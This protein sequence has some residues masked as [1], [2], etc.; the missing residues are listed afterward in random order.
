MQLK[1]LIRALDAVLRRYH[2]IDEFIS[3]DDCLLR[4]A[5]V[6]SDHDLTLSDGT[7]IARGQLVGELHFWNEHIP[8]MGRGGPDLAWAVTFQHRMVKSLQDLASHIERNSRLRD[9][10][11]FRGCFGSHHRL[12]QIGA[13]AERWGFELVTPDSEWGYWKRFGDFWERIYA[14]VLIWTFNRPSLRGKRWRRLKRGQ[15]W[16]SRNLLLKR[17]GSDGVSPDY[18]QSQASLEGAPKRT[19][20]HDMRQRPVSQGF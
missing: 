3:E 5:V 19:T 20:T 18:A 17:Y 8:P 2:N 7:F 1:V 16:V 4:L 6:E 15:V 12:A 11:A 10:C 14:L 13:M 9:V